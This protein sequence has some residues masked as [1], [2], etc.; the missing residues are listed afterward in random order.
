MYVNAPMGVTQAAQAPVPVAPTVT[1]Q[2]TPAARRLLSIAVTGTSTPPQVAPDR[3]FVAP[4]ASSR[5]PVVSLAPDVTTDA[6]AVDGAVTTRQLLQSVTPKQTASL[7]PSNMAGF[8]AQLLAQEDMSEIMLP[9]SVQ[10]SDMLKKISDKKQNTAQATT[11]PIM[12]GANEKTIRVTSQPV[13]N[14]VMRRDTQGA[15]QV[16]GGAPSYMQAAQRMLRYDSEPVQA[17]D[18]NE[19]A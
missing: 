18:V 19:D 14:T 12:L 9:A 7:L 17:I 5:P 2:V 11:A 15:V 10:I 8:A 1:P 6:E 13:L 3:K 4:A 16:P